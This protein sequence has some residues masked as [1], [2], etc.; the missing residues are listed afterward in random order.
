MKIP[1][2]ILVNTSNWWIFQAALLVYRSLLSTAY[3][4]TNRF[5]KLLDELAEVEGQFFDDTLS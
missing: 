4:E 1:I 5:S 3:W 2:E